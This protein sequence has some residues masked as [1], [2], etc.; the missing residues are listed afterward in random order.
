MAENISGTSSGVQNITSVFPDR[1][2]ISTAAA[3]NDF[4]TLFQRIYEAQRDLNQG[5]INISMGKATT[6]VIHGVG[7]VDISN[8]M[9]QFIL[10]TTLGEYE[11]IVGAATN[12]MQLQQ[13]IED[14]LQKII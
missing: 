7:E 11:N 9:G 1:Q 2:S 8:A 10:T 13:K 3:N 14:F 5:V 4:K 12:L 6:M